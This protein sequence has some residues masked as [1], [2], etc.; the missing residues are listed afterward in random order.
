LLHVNSAPRNRVV[1]I[2]CYILWDSVQAEAGYK[3]IEAA[4]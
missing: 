2:C 1:R 3:C 4:L